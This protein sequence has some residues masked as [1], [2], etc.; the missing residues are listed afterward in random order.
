MKQHESELSWQLKIHTCGV[1]TTLLFC[2]LNFA[3]VLKKLRNG[4]G[5]TIF[6]DNLFEGIWMIDLFECILNFKLRV[7][8]RD[9]ETS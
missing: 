5:P 2:I 4:R 7:S 1:M 6:F 3:S 8:H 9:L